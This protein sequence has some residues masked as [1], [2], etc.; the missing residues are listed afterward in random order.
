M[1]MQNFAMFVKEFEDNY[2]K[3]KNIAKIKKLSLC[4]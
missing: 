3:D 1:K 2:A 4:R